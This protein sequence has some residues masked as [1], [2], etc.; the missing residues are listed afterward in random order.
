MSLIPVSTDEIDIQKRLRSAL[1]QM[2]AVSEQSSDPPEH[3]IEEF[4]QSLIVA[5]F[6][7]DENITA[8]NLV[9]FQRCPKHPGSGWE[10]VGLS[11]RGSGVPYAKILWHLEGLPL[12]AEIQS[13]FPEL[14]QQEFDSMLRVITMMLLANSV[15]VQT[16]IT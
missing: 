6:G 16:T 10:Y 13:K 5:G 9:D 11:T 3:I 14:T 8:A 12:P 1:E 2:V 7:T 15:R 4:R